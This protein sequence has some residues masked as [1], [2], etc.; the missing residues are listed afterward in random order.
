M[1]AGANLFQVGPQEFAPLMQGF[2]HS[3]PAT[4]AKSLLPVVNL[5]TTT[6]L[7]KAAKWG[8][9]GKLPSNRHFWPEIIL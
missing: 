6:W 4:K 5:T 8:M 1:R 9:L 7:R 3:I 2:D